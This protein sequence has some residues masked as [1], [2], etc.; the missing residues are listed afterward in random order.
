MHRLA[1]MQATWF[2]RDDPRIRWIKGGEGAQEEAAALVRAFL[3]ER[4]SGNN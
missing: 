2:R 3:S 4:G 1:R